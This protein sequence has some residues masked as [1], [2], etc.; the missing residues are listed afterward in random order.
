MLAANTPIVSIFDI[1]TLIAAIHVIERDYSK[2]RPG[3]KAAV[4]TDAYSGKTFNGRIVRMAPL[5]KEKSRQARI[6]VEILNKELLLKPGMF[7]RVKIEFAKHENATIV[8]LDALAKRDER[9]GVFKVDEQLERGPV[10]TDRDRHCQW[11]PGGNL[12]T[13]TVR[14]GGYPGPPPPGRRDRRHFAPG[15][16]AEESSREEHRCA[17]P[18]SAQGTEKGKTAQNGG[19]AM[20]L[21][22]FSVH[23]PIF[24]IMVS[25]IVII[26]GAVS[27]SRLSIDLMPD[28]TY[29]TLS[30]STDYENASPEEIEELVTRRSRRP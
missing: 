8:P 18:G 12:K 5:L 24:I 9:Q 10:Y 27:L 25:L 4:S 23:H 30:I 17:A 16:P 7:V 3:M 26:L 11:K 1:Y 15:G 29:P 28:I 13:R 2:I 21:P 19:K 20:N 6:E 14:P 22:R